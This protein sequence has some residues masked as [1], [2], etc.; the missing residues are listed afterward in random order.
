M[1]HAL[2]IDEQ[3]AREIENV[4]SQYYD[5]LI[6]LDEMRKKVAGILIMYAMRSEPILIKIIKS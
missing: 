4:S 3:T 2:E 6:S 1:E 5:G